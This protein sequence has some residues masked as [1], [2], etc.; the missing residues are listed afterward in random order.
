MIIRIKNLRIP[1]EVGVHAWEHGAPQLVVINVLLEY[2]ASDAAKSDALKH[3]V[4]YQLMTQKISEA[5]RAVH[6]HLLER[7][8]EHVLQIMMEDERIILAEVEID[9]PDALTLADSVSVS[10]RAH[11]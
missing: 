7:M 2:D 11:R 6:F 10:A 4:D 9:K 5:V 1:A 8:A 3:S